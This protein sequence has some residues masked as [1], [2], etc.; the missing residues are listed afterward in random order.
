MKFLFAAITAMFQ[1]QDRDTLNYAVTSAF[2][3]PDSGDFAQVRLSNKNGLQQIGI[4]VFNG[5]TGDQLA[6]HEFFLVPMT[7]EIAKQIGLALESGID[8]D[9]QREVWGDATI[10]WINEVTKAID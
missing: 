7:K 4:D 9:E 10:D 5:D 8:E 1:N 6:D 2:D 3:N